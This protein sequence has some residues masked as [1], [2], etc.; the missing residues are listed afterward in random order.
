MCSVQAWQNGLIRWMSARLRLLLV[1]LW[2]L[3]GFQHLGGYALAASA[4]ASEAV[5]PEIRRA[6][7]DL[8]RMYVEIPTLESALGLLREAG[9]PYDAEHTVPTRFVRECRHGRAL[10][11]LLGLYRTDYAY[12]LAFGQKPHMPLLDTLEQ[13]EL[14]PEVRQG[15]AKG[16]VL[17]G[18]GAAQNA[19]AQLT[20][21]LHSL[22]SIEDVRALLDITYG[23]LLEQTHILSASLLRLP[24]EQWGK[25]QDDFS[26]ALQ[27]IIARVDGFRRVLQGWTNNS[28]LV[29]ELG[30][31]S[32]ITLLDRVQADLEM[33]LLQ[34]TPAL[35]QAT[36][37]KVEEERVDLVRLCKLPPKEEKGSHWQLDKR[38]DLFKPRNF[39]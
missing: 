22:S 18:R 20:K 27:A 38:D 14:S 31:H 16:W 4:E 29:K 5:P 25:I 8:A 9:L 39:F 6:S 1:G 34:P 33:L 12:A 26:T 10:S 23:S 2:L 15:L 32:D 37:K 13:A 17:A 35:V 24:P 28:V 19:Q 7:A 21:T 36:L 11:T 3:A 30:L